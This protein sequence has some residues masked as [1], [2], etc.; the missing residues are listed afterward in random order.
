MAET[1]TAPSPNFSTI[2]FNPSF[3]TS[4]TGLTV[5]EADALYLNKSTPDTANVLETFNAGIS[6]SSLQATTASVTSNLQVSGILISDSLDSVGATLTLGPT[7]A[8]KVTTSKPFSASSFDSTGSTLTLGVT[9]ATT[10]S[11]A[12]PFTANSYNLTGTTPTLSKSSM[13]YFVNYS[14]VSEGFTTT[15]SRYLYT[16]ASNTSTANS[17]YFN[18][19]VYE[20]NIHVYVVQTGGPTFS[21]CA[22]TIGAASGTATGTIS[23]TAQYGGYNVT[24]PAFSVG[25]PGGVN[26]NGNGCVF[27]HT[28]CFTIASSAFIN[29]ELFISSLTA[30]TNGTVTFSVYG[31]VKRI[32]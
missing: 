22:F 13:S 30:I 31:C 14:A 29:L 7:N 26:L 2:D 25:N 11:T 9:N 21:G 28:G 4:S 12:L 6:V 23:K 19:G 18:A 27:S 3:F 15:G 17:H 10:V 1:N 16:P 20:A 32:A 8:T 5:A 24:S